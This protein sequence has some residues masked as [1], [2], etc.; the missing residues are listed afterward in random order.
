MTMANVIDVSEYQDPAKFDYQAAKSNGIKAVIIRLSVGNRRDNHAAEHIA[1][2]KKYGLKWHG[3]HYWY[4]LSGEAAFAVS[5]AQSLGLT[6]SQYFFLDMEDKSLSSDWSVQFESF[7][8][9]VGSKYKIGLYCS[10]SPYKSHFDNAKMVAE[11]VYRWIAAYSYEPDNYD[12]WQMSGEGSGGF[13]SYTG[14][15]DR[16]Y[17]KTG[18]LFKEEAQPITPS[19]TPLYR[20]IIGE[21]GYDTDS[22]I[23]GLGRSYDNGKTFHVM[24]T[25]YGRIYRQQDGDRI[26]PFIVDKVKAVLDWSN[27]TNKP[28]LA[29]KTDLTWSNVTGKPDVALKS[30]VA[31]VSAVASNAS[32]KA[33]SNAKLIA[34]K[35]SQEDLNNVSST[36]SSALDK[37][38]SNANAL[39]SKVNKSDLTWTNI[40]NRP[41]VDKI[42]S[43]ASQAV[44][45]ANTAQSQASAAGQAASSAS[46]QASA[47]KASADTATA[48]ANAAKASAS[49]AGAT[50]ASAQQVA[51]SA[52]AS[53]S[54]TAV[55]LKSKAD[56]ATV[57]AQFTAVNSSVASAQSTADSAVAGLDNKLD[58]TALTW[59]N[60]ANKPTNLATTDSVA[61]AQNAANSAVSMASGATATANTAKSAATSAAGVANQANTTANSALSKAN[62]AVSVAS[63]ADSNANQAVTTANNA[64]NKVDAIQANGG[65]RNLLLGT[66]DF[67]GTSI[68]GS[69]AAVTNG[70]EKFQAATGTQNSSQTYF[71]LLTF[72][73][74]PLEK[75]TDYTASFWVKTS[76]NTEIWSYLFDSGSNG[77]YSDGATISQSTTDYT[78]IVVHF[79][80][81]NNNATPNFIPVRINK[82]S[83]ITV[84]LYGCMLEKGTVAHDWSP[85]P[86]DTQ[87]EIDANKMAAANAQA[88]ASNAQNTANSALSK[89]NSN[90]TTLKTKITKSDLT[91]ANISGKPSIPDDDATTTVSS[92]DLNNY[93]TTGKY[94]MPNSLANYTNHPTTGTDMGN[95]FVMKV[96]AYQN[97]A[98]IVQTIYQ[99]NSGD[100]WIRQRWDSSWK[101]WRQI[102][103]WG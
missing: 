4:N 101:S 51:N 70:I 94:Y 90:A 54:A 55:A 37:A 57:N 99:I 92:G 27:I 78:R 82:K 17:D 89:A 16:D 75:N 65:G 77:T 30:D 86:E 36:A 5:D 56:T 93:T 2:C 23:Y 76:E 34:D 10:D 38:T 74:I 20:Q 14:D 49:T 85:A 28:D 47:A 66:R 1:N 63:Q 45:T 88:S 52:S 7:R 96:D 33:D 61:K 53:A 64:N 87:S 22:G 19:T 67:S 9:A 31:A 79:H 73:A 26:W 42:A 43:Q 97:S 103:F 80:N 15:V 71:D 83:T 8:S 6:S 81:G 46:A 58:K 91:W 41:D 12:T 35:A 3:Y 13:G 98:M 68:Q 102:N 32:A 21:A 50:A 44:V 59:G 60:I 11:G 24:D 18:N 39:S 100:V 40:T 48:T 95:W 62:S 25:V 84:W 69:K 72:S 29:L